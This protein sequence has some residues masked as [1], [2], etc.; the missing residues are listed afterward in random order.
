[1]SNEFEHLLKTMVHGGSQEFRAALIDVADTAY[2]M[3]LWCKSHGVPVAPV[4]LVELTRLVMERE[5][6]LRRLAHGEEG[7]PHGI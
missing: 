1:M 2:A 4:S 6:E 3:G 7:E 5:Q